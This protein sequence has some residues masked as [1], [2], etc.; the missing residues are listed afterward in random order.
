MPQRIDQLSARYREE[1][2]AEITEWATRHL[3][4]AILQRGA[5]L[6]GWPR[7]SRSLGAYLFAMP[8]NSG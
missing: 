1:T 4:R 8:V 7:G 2:V 5:I 6:A 3:M